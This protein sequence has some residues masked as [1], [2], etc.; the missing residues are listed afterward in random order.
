MSNGHHAHFQSPWVTPQAPLAASLCLGQDP[1]TGAHVVAPPPVRSPPPQSLPAK[2]GRCPQI[3]GP[4]PCALCTSP[5]LLGTSPVTPTMPPAHLAGISSS[6]C[7]TSLPLTSFAPAPRGVGAP[8][9][10][11]CILGKPSSLGTS[12]RWTTAMDHWLV[13]A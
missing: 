7:K 6:S 5:S 10:S 13:V 1:H 2:G 9:S 11:P 8:K 3:T 12:H 4:T